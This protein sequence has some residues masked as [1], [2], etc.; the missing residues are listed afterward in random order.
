MRVSL[1]AIT[2]CLFA[3]PAHAGPNGGP[4]SYYTGNANEYSSEAPQ[5]VRRA[6][7]IRAVSRDARGH[8][9]S[10]KQGGSRVASLGSLGAFSGGIVA[11]ARA[12]VGKT[13]GQLGLPRSLW[14]ADFMNRVTGGGTGSRAAKSYLHYGSR[15][16]GAVGDIAVFNRGRRGGGHVGIKTGNC[17]GGIILISGNDGHRVRERCVSTASLI[18]YRRP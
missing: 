4:D 9:W 2:F 17:S 12:H 7:K 1:A 3:I 18:A 13:A 8:R 10:R 16:T 6:R 11:R 15:G 14:C 5:V